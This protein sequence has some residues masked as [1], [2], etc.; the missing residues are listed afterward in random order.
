MSQGKEYVIW[1]LQNLNIYYP[2]GAFILSLSLSLSLSLCVC[3]CVCVCS[4]MFDFL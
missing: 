4:V 1:S 2:F 3:V